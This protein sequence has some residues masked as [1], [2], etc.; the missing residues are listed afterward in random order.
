MKRMPFVRSAWFAATLLAVGLHAQG[1]GAQQPPAPVVVAEI[2]DLSRPL[3]GL[4]ATGLGKQ[5]AARFG[6]GLADWVRAANAGEPGAEAT[7]KAL[8]MLGRLRFELRVSSAGV[9]VDCRSLLQAG[10]PDSLATDLEL[11]LR[12]EHDGD[13]VYVRRDGNV[14]LFG[15]GPAAAAGAAPRAAMPFRAGAEAG[16]PFRVEVD[17]GQ[18]ILAALTTR[19]LVAAPAAANPEPGEATL[20][21]Q[22]TAALEPLLRGRMWFAID[23]HAVGDRLTID[24]C[25][26]HTWLTDPGRRL[27]RLLP[28]AEDGAWGV[29]SYDLSLVLPVLAALR[30][31]GPFAEK[32]AVALVRDEVGVDL[33]KVVPSFEGSYGG[34]MDYGAKGLDPGALYLFALN[35]PEPVRAAVDA[36]LQHFE[37]SKAVVRREHEGYA[38][39]QLAVGPILLHWAFTERELLIGLGDRLGRDAIE[40]A[41][42]RARLAK[43]GEVALPGAGDAAAPGVLVC[44]GDLERL[45]AVGAASDKDAEVFRL[46]KDLGITR[47]TAHVVEGPRGQVVRVQW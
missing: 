8:S 43:G 38:R 14:L 47:F 41:L 31:I 22:V 7:A 32:D 46:L 25:K 19:N 6:A 42:E 13:D 18:A 34:Y 37:M 15:F 30:G 24:V 28:S 17:L 2:A 20:A 3:A 21:A 1:T 29:A 16:K 45:A 4:E 5:I 33:G 23:V 27:L 26:D 11:A 9:T 35:D 40:T 44:A 39:C 10:A 12:S 36:L